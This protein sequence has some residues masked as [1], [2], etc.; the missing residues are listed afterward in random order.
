MWLVTSLDLL[1]L[2]GNLRV[3]PFVV[4]V[5][6][7]HER[8]SPL[9]PSPRCPLGSRQGFVAPAWPLPA[10]RGP[11]RL[12]LGEAPHRGPRDIVPQPQP[13]PTHHTHGCRL[14]R[15]HFPET[16]HTFTGF[17]FSEFS[18]SQ[19]LL[20]CSYGSGRPCVKSVCPCSRRLPFRCPGVALVDSVRSLWAPA[21]L[22]VSGQ[23]QRAPSGSVPG[24]WT[25]VGTRPARQR[26][27][28]TLSVD[29][30]VSPP[31]TPDGPLPQGGDR[32][33]GT[34]SQGP[35][36]LPGWDDRA[37]AGFVVDGTPW[38]SLKSFLDQEHTHPLQV[39]TKMQLQ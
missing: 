23:G 1:I 13:P 19:P 22:G 7:T 31:Q 3:R 8:V 36:L 29:A 6:L 14:P 34:G 37:L 32:G 5:F 18:W 15:S 10:A 33:Q 26:P 4:S 21:A 16:T 35:L 17:F 28:P 38:L 2:F 30:L 24:V 9:K 12:E 25:L 27:L 11:F 39:S 20:V